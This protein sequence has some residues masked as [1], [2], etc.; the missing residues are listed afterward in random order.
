MLLCEG[1]KMKVK[2]IVGVTTLNSSTRIK[3]RIY[4]FLIRFRLIALLLGKRKLSERSK[5]RKRGEKTDPVENLKAPFSSERV[6]HEVFRVEKKR[7]K[8]IMWSKEKSV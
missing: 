6:K 1:E 8:K 4:V 7:E 3:S 2:V 5:R